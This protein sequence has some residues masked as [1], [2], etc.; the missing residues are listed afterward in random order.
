MWR[1]ISRSRVFPITCPEC[2]KKAEKTLTWIEGNKDLVCGICGCTINLDPIR[3]KIAEAD[4]AVRR[5]YVG[6]EREYEERQ[7][8][9]EAEARDLLDDEE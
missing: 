4:A 9:R 2:G 5:L 7:K 1:K 8:R 6:V 3:H